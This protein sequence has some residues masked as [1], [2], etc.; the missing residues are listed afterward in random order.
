MNLSRSIFL[1][2][3]NNKNQV[4][5]FDGMVEI[6]N[7]TIYNTVFGIKLTSSF[8]IHL[9]CPISSK[10]ALVRGKIM[11]NIADIISM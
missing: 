3:L 10:S 2:K 8:G 9:N 1:Y 7:V 4:S 5:W 11:N 6:L